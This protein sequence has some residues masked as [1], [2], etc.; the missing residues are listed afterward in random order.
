[1]KP[2]PEPG[3]KPAAAGAVTERKTRMNKVP[4][5]TTERKPE[6]ACPT[7]MALAVKHV[8]ERYAGGVVEK[9]NA[10]HEAKALANRETMP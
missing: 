3:E 6:S 5:P 7:V 9:M 8:L 1:M 2:P 10:E 4:A